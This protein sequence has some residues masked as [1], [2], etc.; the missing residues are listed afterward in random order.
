MTLLGWYT[1]SALPYNI[2]VVSLF[3]S[4]SVGYGKYTTLNMYRLFNVLC[5]LW[6][7]YEGAELPSVYFI[8]NTKHCITYLA[9]TQL[10]PV[11]VSHPE[12]Y[13]LCSILL[14]FV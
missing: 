9:L 5:W 3:L 10:F 8:T 12:M 2:G 6:N 13:T 1:G 7:I 14:H 4:K 11:L